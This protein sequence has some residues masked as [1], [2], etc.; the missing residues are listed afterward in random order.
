MLAQEREILKAQSVVAEMIELV[1]SAGEEGLRVDEVERALFAKALQ[2]GHHM[3]QGFVL[4]QGSGDE[5]KTIEREGIRLRRS[6]KKRSRRYVSIFGELTVKRY[7]YAQREGQKAL[8][9]PLDAQLGMPAGE[10]SYVLEDWQQKLVV[11]DPFGEAIES[12]MIGQ[13]QSDVRTAEAMNAGWRSTRT[14]RAISTHRTAM[15]GSASSLPMA[16]SS[17]RRPRRTG[18][19]RSQGSSR[20][21]PRKGKPSPLAS[22]WAR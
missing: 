6:E 3:L 5:G 13:D 7:V 17:M 9:V 10:F 16:R 11:K 1:Q 19:A 8:W 15:K 12:R 14:V 22:G 21:R 4:R 2:V 20:G 18:S